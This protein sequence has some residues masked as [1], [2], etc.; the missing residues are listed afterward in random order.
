MKQSEVP[1]ELIK[2]AMDGASVREVRA[3]L[4]VVLPAHEA[5]VRASLKAELER[6]SEGRAAYGT[7]APEDLRD[8]LE[9]EAS[10]LRNA[11]AFVG[12]DQSMM[13]A[14]LPSRMWTDAE[15]KIARGV[16]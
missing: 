8:V 12:G 16:R 9:T 7:N 3:I 5:M 13:L 1:E 11:A 10:T 15:Q 14:W 2:L 6:A 4:A